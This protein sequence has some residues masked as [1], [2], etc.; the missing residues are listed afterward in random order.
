MLKLSFMLLLLLVPTVLEAQVAGTSNL[1]QQ[2]MQMDRLLF[3]DGFNKCQLDKLNNIVSND[4]HF[5]HDQN[6][7]QLKSEL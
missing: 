1:Y 7:M 3:E 6:G 2:I 5:I 4:F